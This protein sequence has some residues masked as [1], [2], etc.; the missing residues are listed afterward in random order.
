MTPPETF[1]VGAYR[2]CGTCLSDRTIM[3]P[4]RR[5]PADRLLLTALGTYAAACAPPVLT[6]TCPFYRVTL[7]GPICGR[8]C[9]ELLRL[10]GG[11]VPVPAES[12]RRLELAFDARQRY[13]ADRELPAGKQTTGSL[14]LCVADVL[15]PPVDTVAATRLAA[16]A[17]ALAER[18]VDAGRVARSAILPMVS[19]SFAMLALLPALVQ[20]ADLAGADVVADDWQPWAAILDAAIA[21]EG[22]ERAALR[23]VGR[24]AH[25]TIAALAASVTDVS[26]AAQ[27]MAM[28]PQL[29]SLG[30]LSPRALADHPQL[31]HR[32]LYALSDRFLNRCLHWLHAHLPDE[33]N[34]FKGWPMPDPILFLNMPVDAMPATDAQARWIWDRFTLTYPREWQPESVRLEWRYRHGRVTAPCSPAAMV[35]R[36][37]ALT[38]LADAAMERRE[39]VLAKPTGGM[40]TLDFVDLAAARLRHGRDTEAAALFGGVVELR[41]DDADARNNYGFCLMPSDPRAALEQ[42]EKARELGVSPFRL[43]AA[44]RALALHLLHRDD[45]ARRVI[46]EA[47][48]A[49]GAPGTGAFLWRHDPMTGGLQLQENGD[50]TAALHWLAIHLGD[51]D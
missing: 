35:E 8:E 27:L 2:G 45:D 26:I 10:A 12:P 33:L 40:R 6:P 13:L 39:D 49:D 34:T 20:V 31:S 9:H 7:D 37:V 47:L 19:A 51:V 41:P 50:P 23:A 32:L 24:D 48:A 46:D 21:G 36:A 25:L 15:E 29:A 42:L 3:I 4:D 14:L 5:K 44:N 22:G 16:V 30:G 38:E 1:G 11:A 18:G 17:S 43:N 28:D